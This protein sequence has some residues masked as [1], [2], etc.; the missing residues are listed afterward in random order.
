MKL[1]RD[2]GIAD[3]QRLARHYF[4][5]VDKYQLKNGIELAADTITYAHV[6]D[7]AKQLSIAYEHAT[8]P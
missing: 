7:L 4:P 3:S 8:M 6:F 5:G 2:E 1:R